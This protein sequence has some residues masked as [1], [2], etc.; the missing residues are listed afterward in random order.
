MGRGRRVQGRRERLSFRPL[1]F[2]LPDP[3]HK[4]KFVRKL[5][6]LEHG[7]ITEEH[8]GKMKGYI[9]VPGTGDRPSREG[10]ERM[11]RNERKREVVEKA[12]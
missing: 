2:A 1:H 12:G 11:K 10:K 5:A 3:S 4:V 9:H 6:S 8:I 7:K